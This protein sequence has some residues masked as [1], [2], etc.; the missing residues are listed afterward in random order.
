MPHSRSR[1]LSWNSRKQ[2]RIVEILTR[3]LTY[4]PFIANTR[5]WHERPTDMSHVTW[6]YNWTY[7]LKT[8]P[9]RISLFVCI[10]RLFFGLWSYLEPSI[11]WNCNL[12]IFGI[13]KWFELLI[14]NINFG[15]PSTLFYL[16][17]IWA[18][19]NILIPCE[20][21]S[22]MQNFLLKI[23]SKVKPKL[24]QRLE[25]G[26]KFLV[27]PCLVNFGNVQI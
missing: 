6:V 19:Q 14:I 4:I 21:E 20:S 13:D 25:R 11:Y 10:Q 3:R 27:R 17:I 26:I 8:F 23:I 1:F 22:N 2:A 15:K 18:H 12:I 24:F 5:S 16:N 7:Q 9:S